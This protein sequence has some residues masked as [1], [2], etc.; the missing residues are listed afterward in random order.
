MSLELRI[1]EDLKTAMK[2]KDEVAL[3]SIRAVK[4]AIL[5][6]K[7]DGSGQEIDAARE[8][9]LLQKLVKSRQES[10]DI[11][12][13]NGRED[14]AVK[15]RE[16]IAVIRQYLPAMLEGAELEAV[17]REIIAETGA[18]SGKDMGKVMGVASKRLAG[19]AEGRSISETVKR[20]LGA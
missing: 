13:K 16:E 5:L 15:E 7:T 12:E 4:S 10:L 18:T 11:F 3:R 2:A 20:L 6:A 8:V 1:N 14:L 19:K 9:Q 17:V